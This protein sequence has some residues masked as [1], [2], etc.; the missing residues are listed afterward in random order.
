MKV[1]DFDPLSCVSGS[2][3]GPLSSRGRL[4]PGLEVARH[5]PA[6]P[7]RHSVEP[8]L[9]WWNAFIAASRVAS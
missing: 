9:G 4:V 1:G 6:A 2:P 5:H 7:L 3:C 8:L